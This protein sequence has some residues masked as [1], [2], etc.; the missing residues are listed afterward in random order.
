[1]GRKSGRAIRLSFF[2]L[3]NIK[4]PICLTPFER[5][6]VAVGN[7][8]TLEHAPPKSLGGSVKCLTCVECN[9]SAGGSIDQAVILKKRAVADVKTGRGLEID[10]E[11]G[12]DIN[13][14]YFNPDGIN[15]ETLK[16]SAAKKMFDEM[17]Q[18]NKIVT[19]LGEFVARSKFSG[20]N[21]IK[22]SQKQHN[23]AHVA[24]SQLRSAYLLVF[25]LLGNEGN[26]Y[27]ESKSIQPIREQIMNPDDQIVPDFCV[28]Y[29]LKSTSD[30][31]GNI[32]FL[33]T[34]NHPKCWLVKIGNELIALPQGGETIHYKNVATMDDINLPSK[35]Q[36]CVRFPP[37]KFGWILSFVADVQGISSKD[38][39]FGAKVWF[40]SPEE[41]KERP[42]VVM[43]QRGA[44]CAF[45]PIGHPR[46]W[47]P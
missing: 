26:H 6:D 13:T 40:R 4:C 36:R 1:M 11:I 34:W 16:T 12:D 42:F 5:E 3:G 7:N 19:M 46:H 25:S 9:S 43:N 27:A 47:S 8:V 22:I 18:D 37:S 15:R 33:N 45:S 24:V 39:L 2:D 17:S 44:T 21:Q 10:I 30:P 29:F 35:S 28:R 23:E 14:T 41:R 32:I 20:N 31:S 38:E